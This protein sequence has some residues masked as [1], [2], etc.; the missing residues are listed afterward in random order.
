[1]PT[2]DNPPRNGRTSIKHKREHLISTLLYNKD[3]QRKS[4][5]L[6]LGIKSNQYYDKVM[7]NPAGYLTINQIEI[8]ASVLELPFLEVLSL[9]RGAMSSR[10][11]KWYEQN[12]DESGEFIPSKPIEYPTR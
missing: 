4:F 1:M 5:K 10:A 9:I 8:I 3:V 12:S 6:R 11:H 7:K 2:G